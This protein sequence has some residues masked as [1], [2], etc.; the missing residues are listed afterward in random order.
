[1]NTIFKISVV[2][3]LYNKENY[4]KNTVQSVLNQTYTNFELLIVNDGSTDKSTE[5]VEKSFNDSR[6]RLLNKPNGGVSSARNAG[7]QHASFGWIA[8][9]DGDDI[10]ENNHLDSLVSLVQNF[11][12]ADIVTTSNTIERNKIQSEKNINCYVVSDFFKEYYTQRFIN[13]STVMVKSHLFDK[14]GVFNPLY[15]HG[16]DVE[17]WYKLSKIGVVA[18]ST[19]ITVLYDVYAENRSGDKYIPV[20]NWFLPDLNGVYGFEFRC[21]LKSYEGVVFFY[22][23]KGYYKDIIKVFKK[24]KLNS[25]LITKNLMLSI[26]KKKWKRLFCK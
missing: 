15:K 13:S 1:M 2:I 24:A 12:N 19:E 4:I 16:E 5:V 18:R 14:V 8:F 3:P 26:V 7:I 11:P 6:I 21:K 20:E 9:L 10:W 22:L 17:V 23:S 25:F